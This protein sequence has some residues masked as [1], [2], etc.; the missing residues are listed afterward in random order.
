MISE[1]ADAE[2]VSQISKNQTFELAKRFREQFPNKTLEIKVLNKVNL[3][4]PENI[5]LNS[6]MYEPIL[7][8]AN[9]HL[10]RLFDEVCVLGTEALN[11]LQVEE[12]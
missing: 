10:K 3:M 2:F 11:E 4:T 7:D 6:F 12:A 9:L 8:M 5:H 1:I